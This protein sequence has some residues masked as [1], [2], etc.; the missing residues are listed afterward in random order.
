MQA[1]LAK[2]YADKGVKEFNEQDYFT[3]LGFPVDYAIDKSL[4]ETV[5]RDSLRL[6][7]PDYNDPIFESFSNRLTELL[8]KA[9]ETLI[10]DMLRAEYLL[11]LMGGTTASQD[12]S[13]PKEYLVLKDSAEDQAHDAC[14]GAAVLDGLNG[15]YRLFERTKSE[16]KK[17]L[18]KEIRTNLNQL[19]H[20]YAI[21]RK[22]NASA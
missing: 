16:D 3:M 13:V 20:Y 15:I 11:K 4:L 21:Q 18:L 9:Y 1:E 14:V 19:R 6:V 17:P 8:N 22:S 12:G 10:D 7:H 2:L 5:Y